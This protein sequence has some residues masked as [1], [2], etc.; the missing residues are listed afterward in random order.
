MNRG[1]PFEQNIKKRFESYQAQPPA[2]LWSKLEARLPDNKTSTRRQ[3]LGY[4]AAISLIFVFAWATYD[5]ISQSISQPITIVAEDQTTVENPES[6]TP[7]ESITISE[8]I[9]PEIYTKPRRKA[10]EKP[11]S[12]Q[13]KEPAPVIA[14]K[15]TG[16]IKE[17]EKVAEQTPL[18]HYLK[19]EATGHYL[20]DQKTYSEASLQQEFIAYSELT[21]DDKKVFIQRETPSHEISLSLKHENDITYNTG[22]DTQW[23]FGAITAPQ[24]SSRVNYSNPE[25][26]NHVFQQNESHLFTYNFGLNVKYHLNEKIIV[27]SGVHYNQVGQSIQNITAFNHIEKKSMFKA[28]PHGKNHPQYALTSMGVIN[29]NDPK[30][31]FED[32]LSKRV[33]IE[34]GIKERD[35]DDIKR[36]PRSNKISQK[37]GFVELPLIVR[38]EVY[39]L[40]TSIQLKGGVG[41]NYLLTNN[42]VL[43]QD[44]QTNKIGETSLIR[45][46]NI[47]I[48]GGVAFVVPVTNHVNF[49]VEPT[50]NTFVTSMT[51]GREYNVYPF[52]FSI[53][54]GF[55]IPF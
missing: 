8:S 12:T 48:N 32:N 34:D 53:Y 25:E 13:P 5:Y 31:F 41:F 2:D 20:T 6:P 28:V 45:N 11:V 22:K 7:L 35:D 1:A 52:S 15:D 54:T 47:S 23:F 9:N 30:L 26:L 46:W 4:A 29:F 18:T 17:K 39:N 36:E 19:Q 40:K 43:H 50:V 14:K 24:Y 16:K 21:T 42:V 3:Y 10:P 37:L 27:E 38:Y 44:G 55:S 33:K 49:H 51:E